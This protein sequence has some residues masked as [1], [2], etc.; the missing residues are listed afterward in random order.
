MSLIVCHSLNSRQSRAHWF[1]CAPLVTVF[2]ALCGAGCATHSDKEC[3]LSTRIEETVRSHM[4]ERRIPGASIGVVTN[5]GVLHLASYGIADIQHQAPAAVDTVYEIAS[6][7]KQFTAAAVLLL[8]DEGRLALEDPIT[9]FIDDA[10]AAWTGITVRHLLNHTAGFPAESGQF[11]SLK[12]R[13][14][15]RMPRDVM[16]AS[17]KLDPVDG[18]PGAT[19]RYSSVDYFLAAIVIEHASGMSYRDFLRTRVFEPLRMSRTLLQDERRVIPREAHTY[20][21]LNGEIVNICRDAEEEVAGGW[22][23]FSCVPDLLAWDRAIRDGRLLTS[24]SWAAM[25]EAAHLTG[26]SRFRYGLGWWVPTRNGIPYQYHQGITGAEILRVPSHG[27]TVVVLTNLGQDDDL[28]SEEA[29]PWGLADA[30][31]RIALPEFAPLTEYLPRSAHQLEEYVGLWRFD[32]GLATTF[33]ERGRLRVRD[34]H[35]EDALFPSGIDAFELAGHP[36]SLVFHRDAAGQ[37]VAAGWVGETWA[38]ERGERIRQTRN[39]N[40]NTHDSEPEGES[41]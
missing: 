41:R 2:L 9:Q 28:G 39:G 26:G 16:L 38:E 23:M 5:E 6:L 29:E 37:I 11:A 35:G 25:F 15:T 32:D 10:P 34:V 13:W 3:D 31:V 4:A 21:I 27:L 7:T 20:S 12:G 14:L 18:T 33:I 1:A 36:I 19:F 8:C 40:S 22:G 24:E 30:I 17:A